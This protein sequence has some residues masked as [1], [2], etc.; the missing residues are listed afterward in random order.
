MS[1]SVLLSEIV[2][3]NLE[4]GMQPEPETLASIGV[5]LAQLRD[6]SPTQYDALTKALD[7][8]RSALDKIADS[9]LEN[10]GE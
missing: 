4:G 1:A 3:G 7:A 10:E 8:L 5:Y 9:Q 6:A 2:G